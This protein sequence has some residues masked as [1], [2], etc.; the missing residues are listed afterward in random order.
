MTCL[1]RT[2]KFSETAVRTCTHLQEWE[3]PFNPE[4]PDHE[5]VIRLKMG[6]CH[7]FGSECDNQLRILRNALVHY[8]AMY[9]LQ[10]YKIRFTLR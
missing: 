7:L 4:L 1:A 5:H 8:P 9:K 10:N 6:H 2:F 3:V